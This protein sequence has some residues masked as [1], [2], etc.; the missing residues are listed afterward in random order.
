M[1]IDRLIGI[2]TVL[3]QNKKLLLL[4]LQ[5]NLSVAADNKPR[6]RGYL[7]RGIPIVTTQGRA[8]VFQLWMV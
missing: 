2:I 8:A 6:Y 7:P 5:R 1:K 3:Q 4:I